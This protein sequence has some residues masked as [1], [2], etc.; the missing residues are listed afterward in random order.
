MLWIDERDGSDK[1]QSSLR[2]LAL[3][4]GSNVV[5]RSKGCESVRQL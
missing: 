2:I 4:Q 5:G 1:V 3:K